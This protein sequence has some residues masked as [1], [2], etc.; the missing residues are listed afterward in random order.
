MNN[1]NN[2][3]NEPTHR[4][5]WSA[6]RFQR[7]RPPIRRIATVNLVTYRAV[8]AAVEPTTTLGVPDVS[9]DALDDQHFSRWAPHRRRNFIWDQLELGDN[10]ADIGAVNGIPPR[11][12]NGAR[13]VLTEALS[14]VYQIPS[15]FTEDL[16]GMST[17][18][19]ALFLEEMQDVIV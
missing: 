13:S 2:Q 12:G 3:R 14:G 19:E 16:F 4:P 5:L 15:D 17:R 8:A 6:C 7:C 18:L 10:Q 9:P 1:H 11:A